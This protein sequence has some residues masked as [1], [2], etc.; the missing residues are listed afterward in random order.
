MKS[1]VG[2]RVVLINKKVNGIPWYYVPTKLNPADVGTRGVTAEQFLSNNLWIQG[3]H[4]LIN[5]LDSFLNIPFEICNE[6]PEIRREKSVNFVAT[7]DNS[8]LFR[9]SSYDR[10]LNVISYMYRFINYSKKRNCKFENNVIT[11]VEREFAFCIIVRLSQRNTFEREVI[12]LLKKKE[13]KK[14]SSLYSLNPFLD[15]SG[16]IRVG[17]RLKNTNLSFDK[18]HPIILSAKCPFVRLYVTNI[19]ERLFHCNKS[20]IL[21]NILN[22]FWIVGGSHNLVKRIIKDCILCTRLKTVLERQFMVQLPPNRVSVMRPFTHV[23]IDLTGHFTTK[24][25]KTSFTEDVQG[26]C[27]VFNLFL[28]SCNTY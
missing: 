23:G 20:V 18:K 25:F 27:S 10:L 19:H 17:S 12:R 2:N 14:S 21:T 1:F 22:K 4:E 6:I 16:I 11:V 28:Y 3:P 13:I 26:I 5:N 24:M 9:Y 7:L 8:I 15:K